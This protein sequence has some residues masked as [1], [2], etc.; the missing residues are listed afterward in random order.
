MPTGQIDAAI[1]TFRRGLQIDPLSA[2][3]YYDLGLALKA[4]GDSSGAKQALALA[5]ILDPGIS[6]RNAKPL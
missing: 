4:Q 1:D 2:L 5:A 3:L 6:V